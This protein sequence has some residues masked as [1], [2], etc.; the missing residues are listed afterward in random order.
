MIDSRA[1]PDAEAI[2]APLLYQ[3]KP[4]QGP[5]AIRILRLSGGESS[6]IFAEL[7]ETTLGSHVPYE[8]VSYTWGS[9]KLSHTLSVQGGKTLE[10]TV[11]LYNALRA[12]RHPKIESGARYVWA[13]GVCINQCDNDEKSKQVNLMAEIYQLARRVITY[14]GEN[15]HDIDQG[16]GLANKLVLAG[17]E[18][19]SDN[20]V[21]IPAAYAKHNVP[22]PSD[23]SWES[24]RDFLGR[25]WYTRMWI[26]Q[27]SLLNPNMIM[28][29]GK[30][31]ICWD[32]FTTLVAMM[33]QGEF[34]QYGAIQASSDKQTGAIQ[35][36]ADMRVEYQ[37]SPSPLFLLL[38]SSRQLDCTDPKD[39]VFALAS[40][41][42]DSKI[43]VDYDKTVAEIYTETARFLLS[44]HGIRLL[45]YAG[46]RKT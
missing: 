37:R 21:T 36:M 4:L 38:L 25:S 17:E 33:R 10:I 29:C 19:Q 18:R 40:L 32:L 26:V 8:A 1:G 5:K 27:E 28:M 45:S 3:Y 7:V 14:I 16:I 15:T 35:A 39:R 23:F 6:I 22:N 34:M 12:I 24:L 42:Q 44:L 43:T 20:I 41:C 30:V 13:D 9:P 31:E 2:D 46:L 11:S